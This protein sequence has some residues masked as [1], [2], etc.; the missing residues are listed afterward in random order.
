MDVVV[1][2]LFLLYSRRHEPAVA[3]G[4]VERLKKECP[5]SQWTALLSDPHFAENAR[6]GVHL[7]DS[8]YA[9][10]YEAFKADR[11]AEVEANA[12]FS[13]KRFPLGANRDKFL[14][15]G[16]LGKLNAGDAKGCLDNLKEVVEKYPQSSVS[17]MAGMIING[18]NKGRQLRG[19]K[20]DIGNVWSRRSAVLSDS[21]S[22][23]A[24]KFS[25]ER[26]T[27][28]VFM[29]VFHPDSV[30]ENQLLFRLA[31]YNF[32]SYLVRNF[33]ISVDG[34]GPLHRMKV[35]G[36]RNFDEALQYARAVLA[37]TSLKALL[38]KARSV[39]ISEANLP[40]LGQQYSYDDYDKFYS[41]HFAPLK[42]STMQL[43]EEPEEVTT[44]R[45]VR[46][47]KEVDDMLDD[48]TFIDDN[49][50]T[51]GQGGGT[52]GPDEHPAAKPAN[53]GQ[54]ALTVPD[55][56]TPAKKQPVEEGGL[57]LPDEQPAAGKQQGELV[58]PD[59]APAKAQPTQK[60]THPADSKQSADQQPQG[61]LVIPDEA[62]AKAQPTQKPAQPADSKQPADQQQQGEL[63]ISDEA[64]AKAQPKQPAKQSAKSEG[65]QKAKSEPKLQPGQQPKTEPAKQQPVKPK[66]DDDGFYF[67]DDA[68][69]KPAENNKKND[70]KKKELKPDIDLEDEYYDLDGF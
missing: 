48:G 65:T 13:A 8:L 15:I 45:P 31:K 67:N 55:E 25:N 39:I 14:F 36:F 24:R 21:D 37:Q 23:Q 42:V 18:V 33:D 40:L 47:E 70:K 38:G 68:P 7:E 12:E 64:P 9:A 22:I 30:N 44:T 19:G 63:V 26:N 34:D 53:S 29:L 69:Q 57:L 2:H 50:A 52:L 4:Y 46:T 10:T 49:S 60:P 56:K 51:T 5:K 58:I 20:F 16:A 35:A 66:L 41:R 32:T 59:E 27:N 1:Y 62:P 3:E 6:F 61:E 17:E 28:F 54:G 43:L 11:Y